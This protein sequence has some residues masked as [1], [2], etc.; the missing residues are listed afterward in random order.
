MPIP[1]K[2]VRLLLALVLTTV[3]ITVLIM[4]TIGNRS[5]SNPVRN[6]LKPAVPLVEPVIADI[7]AARGWQRTDI[8]LEAGERIHVQFLS[9]EIRDGVLVIAGPAGAGWSCGEA[10]CRE[11]IPDVDWD[12]L[13]GRIGEA[14]FA[15]GDRN[16][17]AVPAS[18]ELQLRINDCDVGLYDNSGR[19]TIQIVPA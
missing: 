19:L 12:T 3:A 1:F 5:A 14:A 8:L 11:P 4:Q 17:I 2:V 7:M 15:I 9:G 13:M 6:F 18:G 16:E 10:S